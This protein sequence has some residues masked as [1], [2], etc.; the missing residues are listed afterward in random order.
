MTLITAYAFPLS[1]PKLVKQRFKSS[2]EQ[3]GQT[4]KSSNSECALTLAARDAKKWRPWSILLCECEHYSEPLVNKLAE[5]LTE[6]F[7]NI[8]T[9]RVP[10]VELGQTNIIY[11]IP[12]PS[13]L[14]YISDKTTRN[15]LL[16]IIQEVKRD[17][18]FRRMNL[19]P[20]ALQVTELRRLTTHLD[21]TLY[22][23]CSSLKYIAIVKYAIGA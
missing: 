23:L 17:I 9:D 19:P 21:S 22:R 13:I 15:T 11:N 1:P 12:Y 6:L 8:S 20:S 14:L 16:L 4:T 18:I 10:R 7:N 2:T 5:I 3:S